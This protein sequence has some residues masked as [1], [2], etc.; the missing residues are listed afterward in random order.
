MDPLTRKSLES[1]PKLNE[2]VCNGFAIECIN[3]I[4]HD[5]G[6]IAK[7]AFLSL[8][9]HI[10]FSGIR[11]ATAEEMFK[12][13]TRLPQRKEKLAVEPSSVFMV[14]I[15]YEYVDKETGRTTPF[16]T[17]YFYVPYA[18]DNSCIIIRGKKSSVYPAIVDNILTVEPK[19]IFIPFGCS[20]DIFHSVSA[21]FYANG[22]L[23]TTEVPWSRLY[24]D[25]KA[26]DGDGFF[27]VLSTYLFAYY[28]VVQ[29]FKTLYNL[30]VMLGDHTNINADVL[31]EGEWIICS[32]AG[33]MKQGRK[34]IILDG[35]EMRI[36]IKARA[37]DLSIGAISA[38]GGFFY[39]LDH[40][41]DKNFVYAEDL[42]NELLWKRVLLRLI[43]KNNTNDESKLLERIDQ[44]L[45]G[46]MYYITEETRRKFQIEGYDINNMP[47]LFALFLDNYTKLVGKA[48]PGNVVGKTLQVNQFFLHDFTTQLHDT[49]YELA[50]MK[51]KIDYNKIFQALTRIDSDVL[52]R[53]Q[54]RCRLVEA[55]STATDVKVWKTSLRVISQGKATGSDSDIMKKMPLHAS[56][57]HAHSPLSINKAGTCGRT[58]LSPYLITDEHDRILPIPGYLEDEAILK[59]AFKKEQ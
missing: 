47:E 49:K 45:Y 28:G 26:R 50:R 40:V 19:T 15:N 56:V 51:K 21:R 24:K 14:A 11:M 58:V 36:A 53:T 4:M 25:N 59:K 44:H 9:E 2:R 18:D 33:N 35:T 16:P 5:I 46:L 29:T 7:S 17:K 3:N 55:T 37:E 31:D 6:A 30:D 39:A 1:T 10:R 20:R 13:S 12:V 57:C 48:D 52:L 43:F 34:K 22:T 32:S 41:Y 42:N 54:S 8:H 27:P 38:I 23:N